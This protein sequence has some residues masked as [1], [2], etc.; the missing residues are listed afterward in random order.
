MIR[1]ITDLPAGVIGFQVSGEVTAEDY[2]NVLIPAVE[3]A[4]AGGAKVRLL[5]Q[6]MPSFEKYDLDAMWEDTKVG[7]GHWRAWEKV[8]VVTD[9]GW[10][11]STLK[12]FGL[13]MPGEVRAFDSSRLA[14]AKAW[15]A[16]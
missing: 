3:K 9:L 2:R 10:I 13:I 11:R 1:T 12:A 15:L 5:Y 4:V 7:V 6:V 14:E 8:A 16:G